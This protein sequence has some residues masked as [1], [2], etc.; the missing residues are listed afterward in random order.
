MLPDT[1]M[2]AQTDKFKGEIWVL[3]TLLLKVS[4]TLYAVG[5]LLP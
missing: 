4:L 3:V 2:E 1:H 5:H